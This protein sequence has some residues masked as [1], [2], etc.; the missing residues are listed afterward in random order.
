MDSPAVALALSARGPRPRYPPNERFAV[1]ESRRG[2]VSRAPSVLVERAR[3]LA[4]RRAGVADVLTGAVL[5]P[6][7]VADETR[8]AVRRRRHR[9]D[10]DVLHTRVVGL[11]QRQVHTR[12]TGRARVRVHI[13]R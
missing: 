11:K 9:T 6:L 8:D 13:R 3:G 2:A 4:G 5:P 7:L 10:D 1:L 12:V